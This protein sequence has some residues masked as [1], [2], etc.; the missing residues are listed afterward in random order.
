M[1]EKEQRI[2]NLA[3]S[4]YSRRDILNYL[5]NFAQKRETVP[6][7]FEGFGKRPDTF[8][9]PSDVLALVKKGATSFHCSQEIWQDP[10][11]ISTNMHQE[12]YNEIRTGWDLLFDIDSQYLDYSKIAAQLIVQALEFHN[13]KNIGVKFSGSKGFHIIVPW[14]AFPEQVNQ[15]KTKDMFPEWP[16]I[17]TEYINNLIKNELIKRVTEL[18]EPASKYIRDYDAPKKVMPDLVLVSSRHLFRM[19]YSLHEKTALTSCVIDKNKIKDFQPKDANPLNI[20]PKQFIPDSEPE[21][22][23][24]LLRQALEWHKENKT[25]EEKKVYSEKYKANFKID[26]TKLKEEM[27]P[28]C[29]QKINQGLKDGRKRGL[30]IL[31]SFYR[32]LG[33]PLKEIDEK[34]KKWNKKNKPELKQGYIQSQLSWAERQESRMPP[35][36]DKDYYK[37]IG[38]CNPDQ[39]CKTIKNPVNYVFRQIKPIKKQ[40]KRI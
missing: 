8:Q 36:C 17:I 14:Q 29:I 21:E 11:E 30:F 19:P 24:E 31:I 9:Y 20:V 39:I 22:A 35:N 34:V 7:Y 26:I 18:H 16:R 33:F 40:S 1:E 32:S 6:R 5:Y 15:Q 38:V 25:Q 37:G 10:L 13:V 4:Y 27:Y 12:D 3:L 28:P 23:R 2:R